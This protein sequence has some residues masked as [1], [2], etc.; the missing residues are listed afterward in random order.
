MEFKGKTIG[1]RERVVHY[2]NWNAFFSSEDRSFRGVKRDIVTCDIEI[3]NAYSRHRGMWTCKAKIK[4]N[5]GGLY[6]DNVNVTFDQG[7]N[8]EICGHFL[9]LWC[10][11][12]HL[13]SEPILTLSTGA[14]VGISTAAA[15]VV[16]AIIV[17]CFIW[18]CGMCCCDCCYPRRSVREEDQ[19]ADPKYYRDE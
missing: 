4:E 7:L 1:E 14:V 19:P 8:G 11:K 10:N 15:L 5:P 16:I 12:N 17:G 6:V 13:I 3:R 2:A 9:L 18:W